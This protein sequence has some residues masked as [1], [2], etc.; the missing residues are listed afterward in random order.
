M[1]L[2]PHDPPSHLAESGRSKKRWFYCMRTVKRPEPDSLKRHWKGDQPLPCLIKRASRHKLHDSSQKYK[3]K[4]TVKGFLTWKCDEF[5]GKH[6][7]YEGIFSLPGRKFQYF[8]IIRQMGGKARC[9]VEQMSYGN[10]ILIFRDTGEKTA[11]GLFKVKKAPIN[12]SHAAQRGYKR[13]GQG[14]QVKP[15]VGSNF[16]GP[17]NICLA[18]GTQFKDRLAAPCDK[19]ASAGEKA[20]PNRPFQKS[21]YLCSF[22]PHGLKRHIILHRGNG[23][24]GV[25]R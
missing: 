16:T 1:H 20:A 2:S 10:P 13:L 11:Q 6:K 4:I 12:K 18:A 24:L 9:V 17:G 19:Q 3:T 8:F 5:R 25:G 15:C 22:M 14:C 23:W 21:L 7:G